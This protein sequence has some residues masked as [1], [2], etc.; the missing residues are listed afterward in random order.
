MTREKIKAP[1][2]HY[3][4][5]RNFQEPDTQMAVIDE[6]QNYLEYWGLDAKPFENNTNPDYFFESY[7]HIEA[8]ERLFYVVEEGNM[9]F[10]MLTG[11]IGCGKTITRSVFKKRLSPIRYEIVDLENANMAFKFI[12]FECL[13]RLGSH[14]QSARMTNDDLYYLTQEFKRLLKERIVQ[15]KKNLIIILDEAQQLS[16]E[17]IIELKNLTNITFDDQGFI[18]VILMGQPELVRTVKSL[19]QID[20]RISLRYHLNPLSEKDVGGYLKHRLLVA[21]HPDGHL[22]TPD[23]VQILC[24]V[25]GGIPRE[26][27]R[28]CKLAID[29]AYSL[30]LNMINEDMINA[31]ILDL[32]KQDGKLHG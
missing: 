16:P 23:A 21:G 1:H 11:E 22:F 7:D 29:R 27:N 31:I 20:Q 17:S 24:R 2:H 19:P 3:L 5:K 8:L 10:G 12:L 26:I 6:A 18:T 32:H 13:Q 25:T 9:N 28:V 4:P 15:R 30:R 14:D